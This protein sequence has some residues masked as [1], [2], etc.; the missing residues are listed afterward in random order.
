M[1]QHM[2][3]IL[4]QILYN[5]SSFVHDIQHFK[6]ILHLHSDNVINKRAILRSICTF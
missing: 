2:K 6:G 4:T 5:N 3:F 1:R